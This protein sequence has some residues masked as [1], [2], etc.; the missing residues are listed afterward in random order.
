MRNLLN[1][2]KHFSRLV[3]HAKCQLCS[4]ACKQADQNLDQGSNFSPKIKV[5]GIASKQLGL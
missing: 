5:L 3:G 2:V 4:Q 1:I